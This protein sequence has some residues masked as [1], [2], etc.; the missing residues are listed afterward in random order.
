MSF[1]HRIEDQPRDPGQ[2]SHG[3]PAATFSGPG[4]DLNAPP[5]APG[6]R[7]GQKRDNSF[8]WLSRRETRRRTELEP[9]QDVGAVDPAA[10]HLDVLGVGEQAEASD[11]VLDT[12]R[13]SE[14][15][16]ERD[17]VVKRKPH[18]LMCLL[19]QASK[20]AAATPVGES[21]DPVISRSWEAQLRETAP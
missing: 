6:R 9:C 20:Y 21:S 4:P 10:H 13:G 17:V 8:A 3:E 14:G 5:V 1:A 18:W 12:A 19:F 7:D 11:R 2:S 15:T 16:V